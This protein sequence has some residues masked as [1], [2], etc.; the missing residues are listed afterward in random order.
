MKRFALCLF[1]A[2]AAP[3]AAQDLGGGTLSEVPESVYGEPRVQTPGSGFNEGAVH[4]GI[5]VRYATDYVFRGLEIVEPQTS[6]DATNVG[7]DATLNFD[8]GRLPDPYVRLITNSAEGDDFSNFQVI[9]PIVGLAFEN[10]AFDL[11]LAHQSFTYPDRTGLDT[12]EIFGEVHFNDAI[13]GGER[14]RVFGPYL[15]AAYDY[16]TFEGTYVEG[17]LRR[18]ER[19]GDSA[20]TLGYEAHV[21]Y[22]DGLGDLFGGDGS[23]FQHWQVGVLASYDLNDLLNI[24]RRFGRFSVEGQLYYTDGIEDDLAAETQ[25]WGGGGIAFRY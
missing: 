16:D 8:L 6:E 11:K 24:S 13:L 5:S 22:V 12:S 25:L 9:R 21:A 17:G 10:E 20:L 23:G 14:G 15:F 1:L 19:V 18:S 2:T 4:L 7:V 3:A